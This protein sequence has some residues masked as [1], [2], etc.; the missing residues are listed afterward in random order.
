MSTGPKRWKRYYDEEQFLL[1]MREV[2]EASDRWAA[3]APP[4]PRLTATPDPDTAWPQSS[5]A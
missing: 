2:I 3:I 5:A 4:R 1:K